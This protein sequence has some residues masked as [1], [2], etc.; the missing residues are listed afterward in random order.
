MKV[1]IYDGGKKGFG[2]R[3]LTSNLNEMHKSEMLNL[4]HFK[5]NGI[6]GL[7][8]TQLMKLFY[9]IKY[10]RRIIISRGNK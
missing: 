2:E 8:N 1:V 10:L 7:F 9:K 3:G 5:Q 4:D 6:I